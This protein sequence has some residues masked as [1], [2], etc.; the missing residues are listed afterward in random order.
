MFKKKFRG[1]PA[2]VTK[3]A[4][5]LPMAVADAIQTH[6]DWTLNLFWIDPKTNAPLALGEV[7]IID[8]KFIVDNIESHFRE[9]F[10]AGRYLARLYSGASELQ[11]QYP[12]A[13]AG[14]HYYSPREKKTSGESS[15]D[16]D[17]GAKGIYKE[18]LGIV[19]QN[20]QIL[21]DKDSK[22]MASKTNS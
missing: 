12:Y 11:A 20:M 5:T 2:P 13:V 16:S 9:N 3:Q 8:S 14:D 10:G 21:A 1:I 17:G 6:Q 22:T 19:T 7:P 4:K 15:N 18:M